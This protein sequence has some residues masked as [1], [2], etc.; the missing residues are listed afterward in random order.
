[1]FQSSRAP[2]WK[3]VCG[4][5]AGNAQEIPSNQLGHV[6][7]RAGICARI[8]E[9]YG[10]RE[11]STH[12][13]WQP[14]VIMRE[15]DFMMLQTSTNL[16]TIFHNR[17]VHE[18]PSHWMS[19]SHLNPNLREDFCRS[20]PCVGLC[21]LMNRAPDC[22]IKRLKWFGK[23]SVKPRA[24]STCRPKHLGRTKWHGNIFNN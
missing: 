4:R 6:F 15:P 7:Y 21:M 13:P 18:L 10:L 24:T 9:W 3:M 14:H 11:K 5:T 2:G 22:R 16:Q 1:M 8:E 17:Y 12:W 19:L 20:A 23:T